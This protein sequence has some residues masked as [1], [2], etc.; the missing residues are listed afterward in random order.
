MNVNH[1]DTNISEPCSYHASVPHPVPRE[2]NSDISNHHI[3]PTAQTINKEIATIHGTSEQKH[4]LVNNVE[5]SERVCYVEPD[6]V[7]GER[8]RFLVDAKCATP[9]LSNHA[10][11]SSMATHDDTAGSSSLRSY[12][13]EIPRYFQIKRSTPN[14]NEK[15][16]QPT[17]GADIILRNVTDV[18]TFEIIEKT[19]RARSVNKKSCL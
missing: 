18:T 9:C 10:F 17:I 6:R 8:A 15:I 19:I 3:L 5:S 1:R 2:H 16:L 13:D 11:D 7:S 12:K 14:S 4:V